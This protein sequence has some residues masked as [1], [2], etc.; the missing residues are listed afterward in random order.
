MAFGTELDWTGL[1]GNGLGGTSY[2]ALGK[3]GNSVYANTHMTT[4]A[5]KSTSRRRIRS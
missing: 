1:G 4:G 2:I 5:N 3:R